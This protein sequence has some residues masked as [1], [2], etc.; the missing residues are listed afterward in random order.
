MSKIKLNLE[1]FWSFFKIG[2]M[3]FGGGLTMLPMLEHELVQKKEWVSEEE[4]LDCYAI[5]QC[6]PG[7]I[8]VNTATFVGYKKNKIS[9]GIFATLG[10]IFPSIMIITIIAMFLKNFMDNIWFQHAL[11]GVRGVVC[12]L[13]CNTVINLCKKSLKN[14]FTE[15]VFLAVLLLGFFTKIPTIILV[16]LAAAAGIIA[17][18][19]KEKTEHLRRQ[20][21]ENE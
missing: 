16:L 19:I 3:T 17:D 20:E 11:Q 8:A 4:L 9:G 12:A 14:L 18:L 6:T 21:G 7:I 5:G 15:L 10:M 13:L 2:G 1:L